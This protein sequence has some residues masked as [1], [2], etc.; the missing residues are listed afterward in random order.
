MQP[1]LLI[2]LVPFFLL[3]S[4][5]RP[6]PFRQT[7]FLLHELVE[8]D[9]SHLSAELVGPSAPH[10]HSPARPMLGLRGFSRV[11]LLPAIAIL[12]ASLQ[13]VQLAG[14]VETDIL[15]VYLVV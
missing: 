4:R 6:P 5:S 15:E 13:H 10:N 3:L 12:P 8:L 7:C 1:S 2:R 11:V 14:A 9:P